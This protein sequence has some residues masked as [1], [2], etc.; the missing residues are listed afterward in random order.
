MV[1]A[2]KKVGDLLL[3]VDG[4]T[5]SPSLEARNLGAILD[6]TLSYQSHIESITKS[7]F[8]HLKN[9]PTL[10]PSRPAHQGSHS[11]QALAAH[12]PHSQTTALASCKTSHQLQT[13]PADLQVSKQPGS[14][15]PLRPFPGQI[16]YGTDLAVCRPSPPVPNAMK[17]TFGDRAF[18]VAAPTLWN[19]LPLEIRHAA[20]L[21]SFK[22]A[23][24]R[25]LFAHSLACHTVT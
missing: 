8:Y 21:E 19:S 12:H 17:R 25:H 10:R 18:S 23:L 20:T 14:T 5:I 22:A 4:S 11:H 13:P 24:K 16:N 2:P 3:D 9:I 6:S 7:A 15:I 1:V